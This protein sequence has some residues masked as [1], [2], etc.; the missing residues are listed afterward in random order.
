MIVK[1][2][3]SDE[4]LQSYAAG[5]LTEGWSVAVATHLALCPACRTR[6]DKFECLGGQLLETL[7]NEEPLD[8]SWGAIQARL[9]HHTEPSPAAPHKTNKTVPVMPEPLRS[10]AGGDVDHRPG[11]RDRD[12][13]RTR[14]R[15]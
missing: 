9:M 13:R 6:L 10:Y 5:H 8:A 15:Q 7:P 2:H 12:R 14:R 1:H 4:L 3:L 11:P